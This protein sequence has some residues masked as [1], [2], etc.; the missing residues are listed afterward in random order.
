MSRPR[1]EVRLPVPHLSCA[2]IS[3][4]VSRVDKDQDSPPSDVSANDHNG[5]SDDDARGE[6]AGAVP[7]RKS[8]RVKSLSKRGE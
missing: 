8:T 1:E 3:D 7:L 6:V 2:Q 4:H 5:T